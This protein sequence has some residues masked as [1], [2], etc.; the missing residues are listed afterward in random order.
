MRLK[1]AGRAYLLFA[2][3]RAIETN[4]LKS[5]NLYIDNMML[6]Y[7]TTLKFNRVKLEGRV[8]R[9]HPKLNAY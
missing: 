9:E 7:K 3:R 1:L 8:Q 5:N 2:P 4:S 6:T